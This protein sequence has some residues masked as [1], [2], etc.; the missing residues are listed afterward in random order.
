MSAEQHV[1]DPMSQEVMDELHARK[2]RVIAITAL[3]RGS[4]GEISNVLTWR[5]DQLK[6]YGFHFS[7]DEYCFQFKYLNKGLPA[8]KHGVML[9]SSIPKGVLLCEFINRTSIP[10][11]ILFVDDLENNAD[12]VKNEMAKKNIPTK[13]FVFKSPKP[14]LDE[15]IAEAQIR[16][17]IQYNKWP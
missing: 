13:T 14:Y 12:S 3:D 16:H 1:I 10:S 4:F 7:S 9:S 15:K 8:Y 5:T 2:I 17:L 11:E 6:Q